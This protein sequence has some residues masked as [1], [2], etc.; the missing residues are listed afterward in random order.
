MPNIPDSPLFPVQGSDIARSV[1]HLMLFALGGLVVFS[2]LIAVL[3]L[4]FMVKY[5]R[6]HE[7]EVGEDVYETNPKSQILELIW[8]VIPLGLLLILFGWGTKVF[9]DQNRPPA[10]AAQ[11]W[12]TGRQWMWKIQHPNGRREINELHVPLGQAVQLRMIS[13]DVIHDFFV[14]AF[15][16]HVDVLPSRYTTYWFKAT[17]TGEF[18]LFCG[19]YCGVEHSK[20]VGKIVVME[21]RAYEAWLA[22]EPAGGAQPAAASGEQLFVAKAC[23]TCHRPDSSARAP[24]LNGLFGTQVTLQDGTKV[25]ADENYVRESILNPAAKIVQGYQPV[26]PTFKG[27]V[28]EEE[29]IQLVNYVKTLKAADGAAEARK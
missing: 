27:Q 19:Q 1:D 28:T 11:Y 24:I 12:V 23:N 8:S 6:K 14:P 29:L 3:V 25:A 10:G 22:G 17:K 20:M 9:F 26:M 21:P 7:G 13:E 2:T 18:H 5:R 4:V 16:I 15:R